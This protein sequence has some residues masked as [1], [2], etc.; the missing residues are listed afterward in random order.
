M[1]VMRGTPGSRQRP[2]GSSIPRRSR[3]SLRLAAA[4]VDKAASYPGPAHRTARPWLLQPTAR[5]AS[6]S[7]CQPRTKG[8]RPATHPKDPDARQ[9]CVELAV[10]RRK[11]ASA[12][13]TEL[14]KLSEP[15]SSV[16]AG[17]GR[18]S[19]S[20]LLAVGP[21]YFARVRKIRS[22]ARAPSIHTNGVAHLHGFTRPALPPEHVG[23]KAFKFPMDNAR[24]VLHVEVEM[25]VR[26]L[27][28]NLSD[29]AGDCNWF[30][31]VV[32]RPERMVRQCGNSAK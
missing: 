14:T 13:R 32:F 31:V 30:G 1:A 5:P 29:N 2:M 10:G 7:R 16:S 6:R 20:H 9:R 15:N 25:N 8:C 21:S 18:R 11:R 28:V 12:T 4:P 23:R 19:G 17:V 22:I 3:Y 26:I 27:P 24:V